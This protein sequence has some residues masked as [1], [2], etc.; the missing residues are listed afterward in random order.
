MTHPTNTDN[1]TRSL[2]KYLTENNY[3]D[4]ENTG[5]DINQQILA[6][7][8]V[9]FKDAITKDLTSKYDITVDF[10]FSDFE[11]TSEDNHGACVFFNTATFFDNKTNEMLKVF[12]KTIVNYN[13][14]IVYLDSEY[15]NIEKWT[16][17]SKILKVVF[18]RLKVA[19]IV[20]GYSNP[21]TLNSLITK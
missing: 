1:T 17:Q 19:D 18:D 20:P 7:W 13:K 6:E 14:T 8:A 16:G 3:F 5:S 21:I 9:K 10:P 11:L 4:K 15:A 12:I 2:D